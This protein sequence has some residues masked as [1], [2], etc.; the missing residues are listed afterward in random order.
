MAPPSEVTLFSKTALVN[1]A[2]FQHHPWQRIGSTPGAVDLPKGQKRLQGW[3]SFENG[4]TLFR[5]ALF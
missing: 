1:V 3:S 2:L 5:V 4:S